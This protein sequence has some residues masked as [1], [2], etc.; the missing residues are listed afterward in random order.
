MNVWAPFLAISISLISVGLAY[1]ALKG[2]T[3]HDQQETDQWRIDDLQKQLDKAIDQKKSD[4][5][6]IDGLER[7]NLRLLQELFK[8]GKEN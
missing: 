5:R 1:L 4:D 7:E 8:R 2:N 6:H 3:A